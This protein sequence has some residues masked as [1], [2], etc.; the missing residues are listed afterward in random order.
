M[1]KVVHGVVHGNSIALE[2]NLGLAE[3]Q[4][5]ELTVRPVAPPPIGQPGAGLLRTEGALADDPHW[6]AIMEQIYRERRTET[7]RELT[8]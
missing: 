5:V 3:G 8:E 7:R 1:I 2:E 4:V 6:D